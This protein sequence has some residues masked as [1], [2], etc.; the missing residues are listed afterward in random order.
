MGISTNIKPS[1]MWTMG[2]VKKDVSKENH[3]PHA[4][5]CEQKVTGQARKK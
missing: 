2:F 5:Q 1:R 4:T 3:A